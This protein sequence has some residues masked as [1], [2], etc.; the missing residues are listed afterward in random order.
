MSFFAK[1]ASSSSSSSSNSSSNDAMSSTNKKKSL[2]WSTP[3]VEQLADRFENAKSSP[4]KKGAEKAKKI[5]VKPKVKAADKGNKDKVKKTKANT[6]ASVAN[7][8]NTPINDSSNTDDLLEEETPQ[9]KNPTPK[10]N[11]ILKQLFQATPNVKNTT[12]SN[13]TKDDGNVTQSSA[14]EDAEAK[15][16]E[17]AEQTDAILENNVTNTEQKVVDLTDEQ[18]SAKDIKKDNKVTKKRA[19]KEP[20]AKVESKTSNKKSN[21]ESAVEKSEVIDISN[22]DGANVAS[23]ETAENVEKLDA[24]NSENNNSEGQTN[25]VVESSAPIIKKTPTKKSSREKKPS[26]KAVK[27]DEQIELE[28]LE[29]LSPEI[30]STINIRKEKIATLANE[31]VA[32]EESV[33]FNDVQMEIPSSVDS[34]IALALS[35]GLSNSNATENTE[36]ADI[37]TESKN[38][39]NMDVEVTENAEIPAS[40]DVLMEIASTEVNV[41][42]VATTETVV[43][44][45]AASEPVVVADA[46]S[47]PVP[48][49]VSA[50]EIPVDILKDSLYVVLA[51]A[52]QGSSKPLQA[53]VID[54]SNILSAIPE[55][56]DAAIEQASSEISVEGPTLLKAMLLKYAD[57]VILGEEIKTLAAREAYGI[58]RKNAEIYDCVEKQAIWRWNVH[59]PSKHLTKSGLKTFH[60]VNAIRKMYGKLVKAHHDVIKAL[61]RIPYD[62]AKVSAAEEKASKA[63]GEYEKAKEKRREMEQKKLEKL[64]EKNREKSR[65]Q[66]EQEIK[67]REKEEAA[68][69]KAAEK[70]KL[71]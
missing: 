16:D 6:T 40:S 14:N 63:T 13:D 67:K 33:E 11:D 56:L 52:V 10:K 28:L 55:Q 62:S 69:K 70:G 57:N 39:A 42:E 2:S 19:K 18:V 54:V 7:A 46:T 26:V 15:M 36:E 22:E 35:Y 24:N 59:V 45:D 30:L 61:E 29:N 17:N 50:P 31:I 71:L 68:A 43:V 37:A 38:D 60:D 8:T 58:R 53:L 65:K 20:K 51:R 27:S 1:A 3:D 47:E 64:A 4:A 32:L 25:I 44:A 5:A 34:L 66:E 41:M 12:S 23:T 21:V 49:I 48:S 9:V